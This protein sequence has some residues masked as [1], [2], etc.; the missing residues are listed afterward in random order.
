MVGKEI[1]FVGR[2][3]WR[4]AQEHESGWCQ[5]REHRKVF[6]P[7]FRLQGDDIFF[8]ND[9]D[10]GLSHDIDNAGVGDQG[11]ITLVISYF[12]IAAERA[13]NRAGLLQLLTNYARHFLVE[14]AVGPM[15]RHLLGDDIAARARALK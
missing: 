3:L 11:R 9:V 14:S 13:G 4:P 8:A 15:Q 7:T 1:G 2:T 10:G 12:V 5:F 6:A